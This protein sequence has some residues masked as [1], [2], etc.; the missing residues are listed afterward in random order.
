MRIIGKRSI[1]NVTY[2]NNF[3][4][5]DRSIVIDSVFQCEVFV[6]ED[7]VIIDYEINEDRNQLHSFKY[8]S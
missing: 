8:M 1:K 5:N 3:D 2:N 4:D 7:I 6:L